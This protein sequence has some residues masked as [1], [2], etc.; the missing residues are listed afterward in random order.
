MRWRTAAAGL[1]IVLVI[2]VFLLPL[3]PYSSSSYQV[4]GGTYD[5]WAAPVSAS[6]FVL[7]CGTAFNL[8]LTTMVVGNGSWVY[9]K[10]MQGPMF[11]CFNQPDQILGGVQ[12]SL[13]GTCSTV[14]NEA[15][16]LD[17]FNVYV[18]YSG[19]WNATVKGYTYGGTTPALT[20]CY[21]GNGN[22]VI[23]ISGWVQNPTGG[24]TLN[25]TI[26]KADGSNS[27]LTATLG[28]IR[29]TT[30]APFGSVSVFETA[31]P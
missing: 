4:G 27:N 6:Y 12:P 3:I 18:Y 24:Q 9:S 17:I 13:S 5:H 7:K 10:I 11:V 21:E 22:G 26:Q 8:N 23:S 14:A 25:A 2:A 31:V 1:L 15:N 19:H 30:T 29:Q 16:P 20:T 28:G